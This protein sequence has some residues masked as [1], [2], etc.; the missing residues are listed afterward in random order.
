MTLLA[1]PVALTAALVRC[2]SVTPVDDGAIELLEALL[3]EAGFVCR[4]PDRGGIKN[5]FAR[6]GEGGTGH[7]LGF[8][9]HTDV[10]PAGAS[11]DWSV[12]P[13]GGEMRDGFIWGRGAADMKSAVA[14][15]ASAAADYAGS[16]A[17]GTIIL[18]IT[19]DEEKTAIDGTSAILDWMDA[20]GERMDAC[21]VGEP[22]C[23]NIL[24][25]TIKIGRRGSLNVWIEIEGDQ[26]HAAYPERVRNAVAAAARLADRL[27][28]TPLDDGSE[29]FDPS[30]LSLTSIDVGNTATNV[31]PAR[32]TLT[33][34]VRFNDQH[35]PDDLK[36]RFRD[37]AAAIEKEFGVTAQVRFR[38]S[39]LC[40]LTE[41][42]SLSDL[43]ASAVHDEVGRWPALST[44]GGTSDA[45]FI[46]AHC[47]VIEC[48]LVGATIHQTDERAS[49]ADI[50]ALKS[51]YG[52]IL[53]AWFA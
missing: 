36:A 43:V 39:G 49:I 18:T 7:V 46:R 27:A 30:T 25:E 32:C 11:A 41:P 29:A 20:N 16:G 13:F 50:H 28:S 33:C 4:R 5:L 44:S 26:G 35:R 24:G 21:I 9:G 22:T 53:R 2:R 47:P 40:F 19:G 1:D 45:R 38:L 15:F 42:G 6:W 48:G 34:D 8:N 23:P 17:P 10:V 14:A 52:R 3:G 12:D 51:I 37:A 31:I